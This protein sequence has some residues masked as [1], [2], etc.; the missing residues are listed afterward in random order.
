MRVLVI[1]DEPKLAANIADA[2]EES[3]LSADV[4]HDGEKGLRLAQEHAY[5]AVVLDLL[6]PRLHGLS[7]LKE[8]RKTKPKL[9]VLVLTALDSTAE[10]IE[11]L[12]RGADDYVTKP[13]VLDELL[14]RL[15]ALLRR[16][17]ET[18]TSAVVSVADLEVD[19][20]RRVA[21]RA[22]KRLR[23]TPREYT[24]LVFLLDRRGTT[25]TRDQIGRAVVDREFEESSNLIDVLVSGLRSKLGSPP[26]VHTVRGFGYRLDEPERA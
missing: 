7:V 3:G 10:K 18:V 23:L 21:V 20:A 5:D 16:G 24:L 2:I 17:H 1:E 8:I 26:L 14:A 25:V 22:G 13:F 15:R 9:P 6:L 4:A 19:L 12:D 11:G